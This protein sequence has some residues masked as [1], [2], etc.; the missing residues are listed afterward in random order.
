MLA[1][2]RIWGAAAYCIGRA[3]PRRRPTIRLARISTRGQ[4][5]LHRAAVETLSVFV[6]LWASWVYL[7]SFDP[8]ALQPSL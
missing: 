4:T 1:S 6:M 2:L 7:E 3:N 8:V 5:L